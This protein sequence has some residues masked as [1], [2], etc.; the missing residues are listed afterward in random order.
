MCCAVHACIIPKVGRENQAPWTKQRPEWR[1]SVSGNLGAPGGAQDA[2]RLRTT[3]A[4]A[5]QAPAEPSSAASPRIARDVFLDWHILY[6]Y[7]SYIL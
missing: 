3:A 7:V 1:S 2:L 6:M 5:E 4:A